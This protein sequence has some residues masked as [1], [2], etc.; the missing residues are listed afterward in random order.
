MTYI[1]RERHRSLGI[2]PFI[3]YLVLL[4]SFKALIASLV[5]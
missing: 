5:V 3:F 2:M 4:M 1:P